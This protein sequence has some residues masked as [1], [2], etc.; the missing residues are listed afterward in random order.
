MDFLVVFVTVP[1]KDTAQR[2]SK[3]I[4]EKK[5]CACVNQIKGVDSFFWWQGKV[6]NE[7]EILLLI[8]TRES[9]FQEL[10]EEVVK[11]HPYQ[12]PEVVGFKLTH[13]NKDYAR[14]LEEET[15]ASG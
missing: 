8:K 7:Q 12:V 11:L 6:D 10:K 5:L 4:L 13:L 3:G 1:D 9:L 15:E 14:W 2:I